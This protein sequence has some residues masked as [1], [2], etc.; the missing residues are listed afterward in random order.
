MYKN[1]YNEIK[2]KIPHLESEIEQLNL[3]LK[4]QKTDI[5]RKDILL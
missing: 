4:N 2:D 3:K 1:K 5:T